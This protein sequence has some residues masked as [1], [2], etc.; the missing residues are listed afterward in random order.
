MVIYSIFSTEGKKL[1]KSYIQVLNQSSKTQTGGAS[2]AAKGDSIIDEHIREGEI[3]D[4]LGIAIY[5]ETDVLRDEVNGFITRNPTLTGL[6]EE[7]MQN[8]NTLSRNQLII[9]FINI[10]LQEDEEFNELTPYEIHNIREWL[11]NHNL[12]IN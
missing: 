2:A 1:L 7:Q 9:S 11:N 3:D 10:K 4:L 12:N 5:E 8:I 6:S